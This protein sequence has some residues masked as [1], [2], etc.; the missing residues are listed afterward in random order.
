MKKIIKISLIVTLSLFLIFLGFKFYNNVLEPAYF[1]Y[2]M[3]CREVNPEEYGYYE[4]G[5]LSKQDD[6]LV[7][8]VEESLPEEIQ[9]MTYRHEIVHVNQY[10]RTKV[11][12][13][14]LYF[15][16]VEAYTFQYLPN[17]IFYLFYDDIKENQYC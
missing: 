16:E 1:S 12:C 11:T 6:K 3:V 14:N 7:I 10:Y 13:N 5:S 17:S 15:L 8:K 4:T 2:S 9:K